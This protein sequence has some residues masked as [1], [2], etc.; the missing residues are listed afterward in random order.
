MMILYMFFLDMIF[1]PPEWLFTAP[2][3]AR[4]G[5]SVSRFPTAQLQHVFGR[6]LGHSGVLPVLGRYERLG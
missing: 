6:Q 2:D 5:G 3:I 4:I 1:S